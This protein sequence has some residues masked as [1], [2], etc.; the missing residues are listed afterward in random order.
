MGR[1]HLQARGTPAHALK[2]S[3]GSMGVTEMT[4]LSD[5]LERAETSGDLSL[6]LGVIGRLEDEFGRVITALGAERTV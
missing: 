3:C 6:A 1:E 4:R 5:A 2:G